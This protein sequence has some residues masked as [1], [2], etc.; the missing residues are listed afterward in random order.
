MIVKKYKWVRLFMSLEARNLFKYW[1]FDLIP[2]NE[3]NYPNL[4]SAN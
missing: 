4:G 2:G 3:Y 1:S